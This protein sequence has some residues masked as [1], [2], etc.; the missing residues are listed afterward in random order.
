MLERAVEPCELLHVDEAGVLG[1]LMQV[2]PFDVQV[3]EGQLV[4]GGN[5]EEEAHSSFISHIRRGLVRVIVEVRPDFVAAE[6]AAS[7]VF[8]YTAGSISLVPVGHLQWE[9]SGG[10]GDA[11][12]I[13][14]PGD[15]LLVVQ[16]V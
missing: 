11:G 6:S 15:G 13:G 14:E 12:R 8:L 4:C 9:R 1:A 10:L 16:L 5:C 2:C 3:F 7:L